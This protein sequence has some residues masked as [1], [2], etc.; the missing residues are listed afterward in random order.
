MVLFTATR[1]D[2]VDAYARNPTAIGRM[3]L[4]ISCPE[5]LA[6]IYGSK[7]ENALIKKQAGRIHMSSVITANGTPP[8]LKPI[9][10]NTCVEDAPGNNWQNELY[11]INSC[12]VT[13]SR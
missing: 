6:S 8:R 2:L 1:N 13:Y 10:V 5:F 9:N 4:K 12:F 7:N 11:S 3:N